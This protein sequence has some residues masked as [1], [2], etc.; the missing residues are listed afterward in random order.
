VLQRGRRGIWLVL[1]IERYGRTPGLLGL[2]CS[3]EGCVIDGWW[4]YEKQE[5]F[6]SRTYL[7]FPP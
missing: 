4:W 7:I 6:G 5:E 1:G 2:F 3:V